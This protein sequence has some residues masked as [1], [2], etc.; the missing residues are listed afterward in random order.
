[1]TLP[2]FILRLVGSRILAAAA[3]LLGILQILDLMD[4]TTDIL[5]RDLG[6]AGVLHYA[7]LRLPRLIEQVA[8]LSVLA[9][10]LFAFT[11][12]ARESAVTALRA[13]G[14]TVYRLTMLAAPAAIAVVVV[15]LAMSQ[16]VAPRTDRM[17]ESWWQATAPKAEA[18]KNEPKTFR[19][20]TDVVIA[21]PGDLQG[22]R[23]AAL[24]IYRRDA[25]GRLIQRVNAP[26]AIYEDGRW[27]LQSARFETMN[28][29]GVQAGSAERMSWPNALRPSDVRE[30]FS[31]DARAAAA[32]TARRALAGV[33]SDRSPAYYRTQ[34]QRAWAAPVGAL[35]MLMLAAPVALANFR[36]GQGAK[37]SI[38]SL[39]SGLL[40]LVVDGMVTALGESGAAPAVLA[41]WSAPVAFAALGATFLIY[42]EG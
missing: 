20:G 18:P 10:T 3:V 26:A 41:A 32:Q 17:L 23:L 14:M 15:H 12:L 9:G 16:F 31:G 27:V 35:V 38:V 13:S 39:G 42:L 30:L 22:R 4:A 25:E 28:D 1:M 5:E 40:F 29:R 37:L 21:Q 6:A 7:V 19:V 11:Q 33:A 24:E 36:G 34:L 8:P 2:R